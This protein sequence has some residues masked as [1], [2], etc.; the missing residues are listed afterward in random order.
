MSSVILSTDELIAL[1]GYRSPGKQVAELQRQGFFRARR[2]IVSGAVILERAHFEAVC[3]GA[4][5]E[6]PRVKP[7]R[8]RMA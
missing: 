5:T 4:Q 2:S 3:A 1:T 6:R 8:L 7:P